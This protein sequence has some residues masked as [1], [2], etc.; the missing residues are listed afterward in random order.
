[1]KEADNRIVILIT[2][3][4]EKEANGIAQLLLNRRKVA[5]VN[6]VLRV[7][8]LFWWQGKLDKAQE[9]LLIIKTKT[10]VLSEIV[11]LVNEIHSYEVPEIIALPIVGGNPDYRVGGGRK[12]CT[13]HSLS[14]GGESMGESMS[15]PSKAYQFLLVKVQLGQRSATSPTLNLTLN[16]VTGWMV[17][18]AGGI[19]P[20]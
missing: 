6:I 12:N 14:T 11:H 20:Q 13:I 7:D 15:V 5:C 19:E 10:S 1:M 2:T 9:N 8:S 4:S 17:R 16:W 3:S 18:E